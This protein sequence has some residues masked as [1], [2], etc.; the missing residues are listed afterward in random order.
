MDHPVYEGIKLW[1]YTFVIKWYS[2]SKN[3]D[4]LLKINIPTAH[5][6][7]QS[8]VTEF[9]E[10][11]PP[12]HNRIVLCILVLKILNFFKYAQM[13]TFSENLNHAEMVGLIPYFMP[14]TK[15][16]PIKFKVK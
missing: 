13:S 14:L 5:K 6:K 4:V 8:V 15:W 2:I 10:I 3:L 16:Y 11:E 1:K 7:I 9:L 12:I